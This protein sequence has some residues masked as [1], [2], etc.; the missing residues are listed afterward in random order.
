[1]E[2]HDEIYSNHCLYA[3]KT[4]GTKL[5]HIWSD[6]LQRNLCGID[7]MLA[8]FKPVAGWNICQKCEKIYNNLFNSDS[9][10]KRAAG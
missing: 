4:E 3:Q 5:V 8:Y 6:E 7:Y 2:K 1:M 10:K 9:P